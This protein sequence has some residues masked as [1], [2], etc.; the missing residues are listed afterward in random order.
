MHWEYV[1]L[2]YNIQKPRYLYSCMSN[3]INVHAYEFINSI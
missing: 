1:I 2:L 3:K